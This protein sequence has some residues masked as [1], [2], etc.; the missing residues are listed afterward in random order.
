MEKRF[1]KLQE[2]RKDNP[3]TPEEMDAYSFH[4]QKALL[5]ALRER[6]ILSPM[7]YHQ[8]EEALNRQRRDRGRKRLEKGDQP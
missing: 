1:A 8:G 4:L 3:I 2:I 7:A 5:L 6:G